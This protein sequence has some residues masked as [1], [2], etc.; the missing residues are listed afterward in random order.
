MWC[1]YFPYFEWFLLLLGFAGRI[2]D[3]ARGGKHKKT[4][5]R[6]FFELREIGNL[7]A[8]KTAASNRFKKRLRELRVKCGW[9]Q[10]RTAE[11]C[12]IG[13]KLYQLYE[14]GIKQNPGL[15]NLEKIA[16]GFGI[17]VH[18]LLAPN[19]PKIRV[20]KSAVKKTTGK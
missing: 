2:S 15:L 20:T 3:S 13:Y 12:G 14:L 6:Q 8:V 9:T 1:I 17:G 11:A 18:E 16:H 4:T 7:M 5:F 19:F 10:E